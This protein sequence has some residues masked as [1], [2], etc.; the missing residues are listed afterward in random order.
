MKKN[1]KLLLKTGIYVALLCAAIGTG[2]A[3]GVFD[4]IS[5]AF[6]SL[7]LNVSSIFRL[8]IMAFLVLAVQNA[9]IVVLNTMHFKR[10]R[11]NTVL[12][13]LTS[14]LRYAALIL[15][16]CWG[17]RFFGVDVAT[18]IAG[19]GIIA[20]VVGFG[21]ESLIEDM[22][23]GLFILFENQYNVGDIVEVDGF[24]GTVTNIG[25]RTTSITDPGGNIKIINNSNMKNILNR[26]DQTSKAIADIGISY[27]VDLEEFEKKIPGILEDIYRDHPDIMTGRP[28]YLGVSELGASAIMLKFAAEV[29]E[30]DIYVAQRVLN[31][32]LYCRFRKEGV[33]VPYTQIDLHQK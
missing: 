18:I 26:S 4:S 17:L 28:E 7:N 6:G 5:Q 10:H 21:A 1:G 12:T 8:L 16:I 24:R 9:A 32:D 20:L 3:A 31:H 2:V 25:I 27:E 30:S 22:I 29:N 19:V 23:I 15:I 11:S 13:I 14:V 33:D